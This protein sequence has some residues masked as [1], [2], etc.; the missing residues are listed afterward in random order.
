MGGNIGKISDGDI[1]TIDA[2]TGYI[3][4]ESAFIGDTVPIKNHTGMGRELF[5]LQRNHLSSAEEGATFF[6][7]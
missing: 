5:D 3:H 1:I 4:C 2:V 7:V 6:S